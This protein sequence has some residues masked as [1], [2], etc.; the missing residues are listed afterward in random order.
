MRNRSTI[1][2]RLAAS[3]ALI[4]CVLLAAGWLGYLGFGDVRAYFGQARATNQ[5][6][7]RAAQ[8]TADF[9]ELRRLVQSHAERGDPTLR[10]PIA[11]Q[12]LLLATD[13]NGLE[14]VTTSPDIRR[15]VRGLLPTFESFRQ[16]SLQLIEL[17]RQRT[18]LVDNTLEPATLTA[19]QVLTA[20]FADAAEAGDV[21]Q[22]LGLGRAQ[23]NLGIARVRIAR[24]FTYPSQAHLQHAIEALEDVESELVPAQPIAPATVGD[25]I[26]AAIQATAPLRQMLFE[27][28]DVVLRIDALVE[29]IDREIAESIAQGL[30]LV[31]RHEIAETQSMM[32]AADATVVS[33]ATTVILLCVAALVLGL[34]MAALVSRGIT[35]PLADM[36]AAMRRLAADDLDV[37]IPA[38]GRRDEIGEMAKAVEIFRDN[39]RRMRRMAA[40]RATMEAQAAEERREAMV[41]LRAALDRAESADRAKGAFLGR[42]SH[43]LRTPLNAIIGFA[44]MMA[45]KVMGP[46]SDVYTDYS[47]DIIDSG[48]H[49][50][51]LVERVLEVSRLGG[52]ARRLD[53][54]PVDLDLIRHDALRLAAKDIA[55]ADAKIEMA[56]A[57]CAFAVGDATAIRQI[58]VNLVANAARHGRAGG[59]IAIAMTE[60]DDGHARIVVNNEGDP[61]D[62]SILRQLGTP[63]IGGGRSEI[64]GG[65]AGLGLAISVELARLMGGTLTLTNTPT[66]VRA[67]LAL[68]ATRERPVP[69]AA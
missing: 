64:A 38:S 60:D 57:P 23:D 9:N 17:R 7:I 43:E 53:T 6:V 35:R 42:M 52:A 18:V 10:D 54:T 59:T 44:E 62:E 27:A 47:R 68:P 65:G 45:H 37:S 5:N 32:R 13:L 41:K 33:T 24:F 40:E 12:L 3:Y 20:A 39:A 26:E 50:L 36:T 16:A 48:R 14:L 63:F 8:I 69:A 51:A 46:I 61:I 67:E 34:A 30:D 1:G 2:V 11:T 49:L 29:Q 22:L 56:G 21:T 25:K 58:M 55:K 15:Q 19:R 31:F 28:G 66:G 4:L